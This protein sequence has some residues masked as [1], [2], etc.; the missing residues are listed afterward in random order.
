MTPRAWLGALGAAAL[1]CFPTPLSVSADVFRPAYLEELLRR[2]EAG[3]DLDLELW[4]LLSFELWCRRFLDRPASA[5][6]FAPPG[7]AA[8]PSGFR[9]ERNAASTGRTPASVPAAASAAVVPLR[10]RRVEGMPP[11]YRRGTALALTGSGRG[12]EP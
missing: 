10:R 6:A 2:H 11:A 7:A 4:T 5:A 8:A 3:R 9:P 12:R 1:A